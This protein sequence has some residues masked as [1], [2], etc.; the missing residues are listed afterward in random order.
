[1]LPFF[2][3]AAIAVGLLFLILLFSIRGIAGKIAGV[4][5]FAVVIYFVY[6]WVHPPH[7][8]PT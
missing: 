8:F 6:T 1:M 7:H 3:A 4:V 2:A 5:V